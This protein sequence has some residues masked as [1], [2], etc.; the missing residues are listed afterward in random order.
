MRNKSAKISY[1]PSDLPCENKI[2]ARLSRCTACA[3]VFLIFAVLYLINYI[4]HIDY[5]FFVWYNGIDYVL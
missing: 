2:V 5:Y 3:A 1:K 4:T